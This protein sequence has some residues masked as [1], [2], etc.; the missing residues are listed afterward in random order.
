MHKVLVIDDAPECRQ[1]LSR[2]LE[3]NGHTVEC[4]GDGQEGLDKLERFAADTIILDLRMPVMD[5]PSFLERMRQHPE[6]RDIHV[7]VFTG[8]GDRVSAE[9][10]SSLGVSE[11]FM[12]G[13]PNLLRLLRVVA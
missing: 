6:W 10:L 2:L 4:A 9:Q 13:A 8:C 7:V 1:A 3:L 12:K 5:G 11:I